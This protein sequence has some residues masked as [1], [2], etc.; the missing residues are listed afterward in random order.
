MPLATIQHL[1]SSRLEDMAE[2]VKYL[3]ENGY[4]E[5]AMLLREEGLS[6]AAAYDNGEDFFFVQDYTTI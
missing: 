4:Y 6:L 2:Q 1:I 5:E 3:A